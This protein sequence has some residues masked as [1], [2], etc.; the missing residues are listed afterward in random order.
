MDFNSNTFYHKAYQTDDIYYI[1]VCVYVSVCVRVC[2]YVFNKSLVCLHG[3]LNQEIISSL[4]TENIKS[5]IKS[6]KK[7]DD[8]PCAN[9][10]ILNITYQIC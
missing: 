8:R 9:F 4:I 2:A 7:K 1:L 10:Q 3:R 5:E 6:Q